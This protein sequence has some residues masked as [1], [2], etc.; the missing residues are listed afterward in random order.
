MD[1]TLIPGSG[2]VFEIV[3]D[4]RLVFSKKQLGRFPETREVLELIPA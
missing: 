2:G 3:V 1:A 4:G